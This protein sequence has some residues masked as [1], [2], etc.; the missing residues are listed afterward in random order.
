MILVDTSI[1]VGHLRSGNPELAG[2]LEAGSVLMHPH[3]LG[4]IACGSVRNRTELLERL[5]SL[6]LAVV[7]EDD[8]VFA[9]INQRRLWGRGLGW[10]DVHLLASALLTHCSLWTSDRALGDAAIMAGVSDRE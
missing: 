3:V 7:S 2:L 1:W 8:E 9:M 5:R 6:P 4:E 10:T